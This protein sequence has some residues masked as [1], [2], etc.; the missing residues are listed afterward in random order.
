MET[1]KR[2]LALFGAILLAAMVGCGTM[3]GIV[4]GAEDVGAGI[5]QDAR[6][7]IDGVANR[8]GRD[9]RDAN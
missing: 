6:A 9:G 8:D 1:Q 5:V 3:R 2:V 4:D 7:A